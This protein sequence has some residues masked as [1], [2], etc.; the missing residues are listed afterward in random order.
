MR[1][2][3]KTEVNNF[4]S[5]VVNVMASEAEAFNVT[6]SKDKFA[7]KTSLFGENKTMVVCPI[8]GIEKLKVEDLEKS[9]NLAFAFIPEL[10]TSRVSKI[11]EGYYLLRSIPSKDSVEVVNEKGKVVAKGTFD[12]EGTIRPQSST[13][14]A[15][16]IDITVDTPS[17]SGKTCKVCITITLDLPGPINPK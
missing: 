12:L 8:K 15:R 11:E 5:E 3:L 4:K 1:K 13:A 16:I 2:V 9:H 6:I 7:L 17:C 14:T 10:N